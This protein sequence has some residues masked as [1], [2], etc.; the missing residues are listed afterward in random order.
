[1]QSGQEVLC[2]R[3]MWLSFCLRCV[4]PP[5]APEAEDLRFCQPTFKQEG[6]R[7]HALGGEVAE[8]SQKATHLL[9]SKV[10][11]TV[12]FLTAMSVVKYITTPEWLEES[13]RSQKFVDEQSYTLRDAE[14]EVLFSFSL[15]ESLKRAHSAPLFKVGPMF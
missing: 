10:T 6:Q 4:E 11:R 13:W 12:K 15:E 14:A 1:P 2:F 3:L 9:A 7:L 8:S 5:A